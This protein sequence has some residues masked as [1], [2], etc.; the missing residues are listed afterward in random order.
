MELERD[1]S[2]QL[3]ESRPLNLRKDNSSVCVA[4]LILIDN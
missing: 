2:S 1:T 4:E 3:S